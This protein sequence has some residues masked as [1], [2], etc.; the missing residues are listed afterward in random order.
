MQLLRG[1]R[2]LNRVEWQAVGKPAQAVRQQRVRGDGNSTLL[3]N[4]RNRLQG[5]QIGLFLTRNSPTICPSDE[6]IS[7]P[8]I[9]KNVSGTWCRRI[10]VCSTSSALRAPSNELWSVMAI[11]ERPLAAAAFSI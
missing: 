9:T 6:L 1:V 3:V 10:S 11:P 4:G 2:R 7:S 5:R 8:G